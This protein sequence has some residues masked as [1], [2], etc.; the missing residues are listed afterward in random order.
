VGSGAKWE[1][2]AATLQEKKLALTAGDTKSVGVGGLALGGGIGWLVRKYGLTIDHIVG[3]E[4]VTAD[5][6]ILYVSEK[7]NTDLFWAIRG[8]GGNFG[9]VTYFDFE[10]KPVTDVFFGSMMFDFENLPELLKKWRNYMKTADENLTTSLMLMPSFNGSPLGVMILVCYAD[11][12]EMMAMKA[13]EPIKL[14]GKLL[15]SDIK[16]MPYKSVLQDAHQPQG[17]LVVVKSRFFEDFSDKVIETINKNFGKGTNRF[18]MLRNI[19]GAMN[20]ISEDATAFA[21][22][23]SEI[24]AIAPIFVPPGVSESGMPAILA[25]WE[26]V[27][28]LGKGAY[29]NFLSTITET[30]LHDIYP[31]NTYKKLTEVK[32]KYDPH[33]IFHMNYNIKP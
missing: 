14:F 28:L 7:E 18:L 4:M 30:D 1:Q 17:M 10:A 2:V 31:K 13:I 29:S 32:K 19:A 25:P 20:K 9:V 8:G 26:E 5:G 22:R 16:R 24:M 11:A 33:N 12:N 6:K 21:Y 23:N 15:T 3:A 27:S